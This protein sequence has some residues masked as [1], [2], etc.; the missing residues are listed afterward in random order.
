MIL[1]PVGRRAAAK[2]WG[3]IAIIGYRSGAA[4]QLTTV[5]ADYGDYHSDAALRLQ[6]GFNHGNRATGLELLRGY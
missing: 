2:F 1:I 6:F 3:L 4:P 5:F